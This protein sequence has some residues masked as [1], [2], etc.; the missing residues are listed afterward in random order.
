MSRTRR[1]R[2]EFLAA[3]VQVVEEVFL[4]GCTLEEITNVFQRFSQ[5]QGVELREVMFRCDE[6]WMYGKWK[7][8]LRLEGMR[9][10]NEAEVQE[11]QK[12]LDRE[13]VAAR[14]ERAVRKEREIKEFERL[15]RKYGQ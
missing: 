10:A 11:R 5:E 13:R 1:E 4:D 3:R 15:K 8:F 14:K 6:D 9:D 12:V 7:Q 2:E